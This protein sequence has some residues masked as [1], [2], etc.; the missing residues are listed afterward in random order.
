MQDTEAS[1][2]ILV[3][4]LRGLIESKLEGLSAAEVS[5]VSDKVPS[6][7]SMLEFRALRD[8]FVSRFNDPCRV[9]QASSY[10]DE[11]MGAV[12][13]GYDLPHDLVQSF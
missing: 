6:Y 5:L 11:L 12:K 8:K 1:L 9:P 10:S 4:T 7:K 3:K 2:E 13:V